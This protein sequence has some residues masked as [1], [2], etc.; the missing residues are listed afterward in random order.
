MN[1]LQRTGRD[2]FGILAPV[3]PTARDFWK[4]SLSFSF[5]SSVQTSPA[6]NA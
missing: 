5:T 6:R 2:Q 1:E 4:C 3:T